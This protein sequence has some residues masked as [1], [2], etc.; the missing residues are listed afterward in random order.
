MDLRLVDVADDDLPLIVQWLH[1][2]QVRPAWGDTD[3]NLWL[4]NEPP[5][6]GHRRAIVEAD[7]RKVGLVLWQHPARQELDAAGLA[8]IP[9]SVI[10]VDIMIGELDA[11]GRGLGSRALRLVAEAA[12]SHSSVPFVMACVRAEN[13]PSLRAFSRAG[14]RSEREFDD[15]PSGRYILMVRHRREVHDRM[16]QP[17]PPARRTAS[18]AIAARGPAAGRAGPH[19]IANPRTSATTFSHAREYHRSGPR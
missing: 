12:L 19:A 9:T 14:F 13:L 15:A 1:G 5:A 16:I 10:D 8:D 3:A 6:S 18:V 17:E 4:L 11:V 2:E 7:S